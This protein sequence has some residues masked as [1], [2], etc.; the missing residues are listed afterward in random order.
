MKLAHLA[1]VTPRKCGLYETTRELVAAL[2]T[3]GIDSRIVDPAPHKNPIGWAAAED[4]GVP[5]AN[6][7]WAKQADLLISHSGL[8]ELE[9]LDKPQ[10]LVA[11]GRPRS[12][13]LSEASGGAPIYSYHYQ[14]NLNPKLKAC[15]TFWPQHESYLQV[16]YP[17]KPV[18]Y[19]QSPV[20]LDFW[21]PDRSNYDFG[22][23][24]GQTNFVCADSFRDDIDCFEPINAFC[25][26]AR[27]YPYL[28]AKLHVFGKP[29]NMRGW[30]ALLQRL[31]DDGSLGLV[32]GWAANLLPV[33]QAADLVLTGHTIDVRTVREAM[34]TGC[35]VFRISDATCYPKIRQ[36]LQRDRA[37]VRKDAERLFNPSVT[38]KQFLEVVRSAVH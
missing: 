14:S 1:V 28:G 16:M 22:G 8:G 12:S 29:K 2:R 36:A 30:G 37:T 4:R 24:A 15:V 26:F 17:N 20:D 11:H 18:H 31:K 25:L 33:Y 35:P 32:Q 3:K 10:I 34:A 5:I 38:A 19:I 7:E 9:S 27:A 13:F 6:I 21:H 23:H